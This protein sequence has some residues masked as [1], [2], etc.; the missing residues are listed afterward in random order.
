MISCY[1]TTASRLLRRPDMKRD[2]NI[3]G[4]T[5]FNTLISPVYNT[6]TSPVHT[7]MPQLLEPKTQKIK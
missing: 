2:P 6:L 1:A 7:N 4:T 5:G 3:P